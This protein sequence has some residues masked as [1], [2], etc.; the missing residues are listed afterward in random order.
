VTAST[1]QSPTAPAT[2]GTLLHLGGADTLGLLHRISTQSLADLEPGAARATL[3]CD[4]R[5]R[6][7]HRAVVAVA[8][9]RSVWLLRDD[10]PPDALAAHV[11]RHVF[12]EDVRIAAAPAAGVRLRFGATGEPAGVVVE[13][14]GMPLRVTI[15]SDLALEITPRDAG[16]A[17]REDEPRRIARG[18]PRH[19]HEIQDAFNPYEVGLATEVHLDKGCYTGQEVL[20]RLMTYESVR[21]GLARVRGSGAAP[22]V[23]AD[24]LRDGERVGVLT[25]AATEAGGWIGLAVLKKE[26]LERPLG[27]A[28]EDGAIEE[29]VAIP[30]AR[31]LGLP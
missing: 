25:S 15:A 9:D 23:P 18:L 17:R 6:L 8:R 7:L 14:S 29:A 2:P 24:V 19:G 1:H 4:F 21:R 22:A 11:D 12:R 16:G 26:V 30:E 28:L 10:A 20:L 5:G 27:L 3:F 31:P 13:A